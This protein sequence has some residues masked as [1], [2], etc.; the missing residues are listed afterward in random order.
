MSAQRRKHSRVRTWTLSTLNRGSEYLLFFHEGSQSWEVVE[1]DR[2]SQLVTRHSPTVVTKP[3]ILERR[4][5]RSDA[6]QGAERRGLSDAG[7]AA[8]DAGSALTEDA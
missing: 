6:T 2:S 1:L 8:V 7:D 3:E 4:R 5:S